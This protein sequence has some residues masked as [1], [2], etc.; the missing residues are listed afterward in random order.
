MPKK[1]NIQTTQLARR[2]GPI[3]ELS[4]HLSEQI[5]FGIEEARIQAGNL[6]NLL[7]EREIRGVHALF[8]LVDA[9]RSTARFK[10]DRLPHFL[11]RLPQAK[12][13]LP[14]ASANRRHIFPA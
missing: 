5:A 4:N 9:D 10:T 13:L 2:L 14:Q 11:L 8:V 6:R 12:A 3:N 7:Y 1:A